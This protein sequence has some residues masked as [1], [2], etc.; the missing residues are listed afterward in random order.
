MRQ[1][2]RSDQLSLEGLLWAVQGVAV[3][4]LAVRAVDAVRGEPLELTGPLPDTLLPA[5]Q[6]VTGPLSGTVVLADAA[7]REHLLALLPGLLVVALVVVGARLLLGIVR[8][9]RDGDPFTTRN[10]RRLTRL[11]VLVLVG[12]L[13]AQVLGSVVHAELLAQA[14]PGGEGLPRSFDLSFWPAPVAVGIGFLAE[15]FARG[16]RL[17]EDVEGLV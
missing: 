9:L 4:A 8:G 14:L 6:G 3:L 1:W 11:G 17:R 12:G 16:A 10:A 5:V 7:P 2:S 15:V 13:G